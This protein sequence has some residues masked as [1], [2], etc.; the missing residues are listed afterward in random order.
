[1]NKN[2]ISNS[3]RK[4]VGLFQKNLLLRKLKVVMYYFDSILVFFIKKPKYQKSK[5]KKILLIYNLAFGDGVIFRCSAKNIRKVY[6]KKDYDITLLCQKGI[7]KLYKKDDLYDRIIS[8]DFNKS[9]INIK[10]RIKNYKILRKEYYDIILDPIG[11]FEWTTNIFYTK[12]AVGKEKIGL[13]DINVK[14][15]CNENKIHKIYDKIIKIETPDL[16][17]IEYYNCFFKGLLSKKS[18]IKPELVKLNIENSK[19][20]LPKEYFIIFPGASVKLKRWPIKRYAELAEKIVNK[21]GFELVLVGTDAD[22]E[23]IDELKSKLTIPYLDLVNKTNL[24]DYIYV[25][26]NSKLLVTNDTSAYHIGVVQEVPTAIITGAYT[27]ERYVLYDFEGKEKYRR[28]CTIVL[29]KTC[30]NCSNRCPYLKDKEVWP[31][32]DEITID[33]AWKKLNDYIDI[34]VLGGKNEN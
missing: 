14:L 3:F 4:F 11:I 30:K 21:T 15:Y 18:N 16:S 27:L 29:N 26:D 24:N 6:P 32:L 34:N 9:T 7:D 12:A 10:E 23:A 13:R 5:K 2:Y 17:L 22:K 1:M 28:P 20:K 33:Y 25:I 19:I 31:C 8:I